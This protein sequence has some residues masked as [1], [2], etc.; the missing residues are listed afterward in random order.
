MLLLTQ[1]GAELVAPR[2]PPLAH[3]VIAQRH[4]KYLS[5]TPSTPMS[6]IQNLEKMPKTP[7]ILGSIGLALGIAA[8]CTAIIGSR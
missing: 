6:W 4:K 3:Q 2:S 5:Q 1:R 8:V 7:V